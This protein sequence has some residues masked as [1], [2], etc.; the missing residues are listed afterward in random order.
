M[1]QSSTTTALYKS[2]TNLL[3]LLKDQGFDTKDYERI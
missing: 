3:S 2:R 1:A